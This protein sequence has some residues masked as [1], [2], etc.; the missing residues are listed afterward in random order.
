VV[1]ALRETPRSRPFESLDDLRGLE[2]PSLVV[3]S[4]DAADPGHPYAVAE[5]YA[6]VLPDARLVS[7]AEG[8][9][10]LAWQ[11]GRLSREIAAFA[12]ALSSSL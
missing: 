4:H 7:E 9:S 2:V 8:E 12:E 11:G 1:A 10:P 6:E 5:A 3:A